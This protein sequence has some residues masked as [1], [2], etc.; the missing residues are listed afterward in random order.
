MQNTRIL[1]SADANMAGVGGGNRIGAPSGGR[2]SCRCSATAP[3]ASLKAPR[4]LAGQ[5]QLHGHPQN[6]TVKRL[7]RVRARQFLAL[8]KLGQMS[9]IMSTL[10]YTYCPAVSGQTENKNCRPGLRLSD[11]VI[12]TERAIRLLCPATDEL[13][14]S[15]GVWDGNH[16]PIACG[17]VSGDH[18]NEFQC[19]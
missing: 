14:S 2:G 10:Y 17:A 8:P 15:I 1:A 16:C 19:Q 18:S 3:Q 11:G 4:V 13:G 6:K 5:R 12:A 7:A 9:P